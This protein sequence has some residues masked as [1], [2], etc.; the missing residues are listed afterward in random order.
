MFDFS[1]LTETITDLVGSFTSQ[2]EQGTSVLDAL[3]SAGLD[4]S[5]LTGLSEAEIANLLEGI[6]VDPAQIAE[7]QIGE[8]LAS[9]GLD[10]NL[11]SIGGDESNT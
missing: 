5:V 1:R 3:Q 2:S 8:L 6:G 7:G 9:V 4:P 10:S 11:P